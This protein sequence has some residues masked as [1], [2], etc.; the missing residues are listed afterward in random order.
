[1]QPEKWRNHE[2]MALPQLH[3]RTNFSVATFVQRRFAIVHFVT[4]LAIVLQVI[5]VAVFF[6]RQQATGVFAVP[7]HL[8]RQ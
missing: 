5:E 1:M 3:N 6:E 7:V 2:K 8:P 4:C